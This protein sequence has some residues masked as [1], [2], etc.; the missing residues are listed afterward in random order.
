MGDVPAVARRIHAGR[1][2]L[3]QRAAPAQRH[4]PQRGPHDDLQHDVHRP[5]DRLQLRHRERREQIPELL[6]QRT[7]ARQGL[8]PQGHAI[9]LQNDR[10]PLGSQLAELERWWGAAFGRARACATQQTPLLSTGKGP[11]NACE[12]SHW[13]YLGLR[14]RGGTW[15]SCRHENAVSDRLLYV[16]STERYVRS[17]ERR[18]MMIGVRAA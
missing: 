8:C 10:Q 5:S 7:S 2:L 6:P 11:Q 13:L 16:L 12:A 3:A 9:V 1:A 15:H 14:K 17:T 18:V 4:V